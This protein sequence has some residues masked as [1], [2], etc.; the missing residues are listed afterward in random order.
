MNILLSIGIAWIACQLIKII[1]SK[2]ISA[3]WN[4]GGMPSAHSSLVGALATAVAL[5]EGFTSTPAVIS[6]VILTIVV[7]DAVHLRHTLKEVLVGLGVGII[8]VSLLSYT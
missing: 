2:K 8:V 3:F 1:L 4:V 6:Y 5:Q 7:R